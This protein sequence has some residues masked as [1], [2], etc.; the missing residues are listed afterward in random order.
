MLGRLISMFAGRKLAQR[1]GGPSAGSLGAIAGVA[2]PIV[3]KRFGPLG[4]LGALVGGYAVK[5]V[6]ERYGQTPK[7]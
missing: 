7:P 2:V 1:M 4:M 3:L 5:K 6:A